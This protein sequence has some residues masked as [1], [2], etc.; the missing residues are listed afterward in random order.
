MEKIEH[1]PRR[2]FEALARLRVSLTD[3]QQR[4]LDVEQDHDDVRQLLE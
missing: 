1:F 3:S 4:L 2:V